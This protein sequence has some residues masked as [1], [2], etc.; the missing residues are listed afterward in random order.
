[1]TGYGLAVEYFLAVAADGQNFFGT[2]D[3]SVGTRVSFDPELMFA[4][5]EK[6]LGHPVDH[7]LAGDEGLVIHEDPR[8]ELSWPCK[9]WRVD[10]LDRP[11][12]LQPGNRWLR[13]RAVTVRGELPAWRVFGNNGNDVAHVL[14]QVRRLNQATA[15]TLANILLDVE[16]PGQDWASYRVGPAIRQPIGAA[17]S[18][19]LK[20]VDAAARANAPDVF[21]WD[22]V[23][24]V[25]VIADVA[26]QQARSAAAATMLTF[27]GTQTEHPS[28]TEYAAAW[29]RV[30]GSPNGQL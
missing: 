25:D 5:R 27:G 16:T 4:A 8:D 1:M 18:H 3:P 19:L 23:D 17:I 28:R 22:D 15:N 2:P 6:R 26:W 11:M 21:A 29:T 7:V 14:E 9:L 10:D 12:R 24:E 20:E 30:M 13:C